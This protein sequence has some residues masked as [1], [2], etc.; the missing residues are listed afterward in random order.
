MDFNALFQFLQDLQ[1]NNHKEWMDANRKQYQT[2][3]NSFIQWLDELD[4]KLAAID[5]N[6]YPTS[7]K[8]GINRINNNL[9]FHPNKPVYKDHFAAGLDQRTK[10]GDFYI[11]IGIN[12]C[13]LAGG[14]WRPENK[15]LNSIREA[16]DYNGEELVKILNKKSFKQTF[17]GMYLDKDKLKTTPKGYSS[18]HEY[19]DLLRH[20]TFAV[21][22]PLNQKDILRDDFMDK[23][24]TVYKEMLPFRRYF[25]QAVTV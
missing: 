19:I 9:L 15:M 18:D 14:Y 22:H 17:G 21:I 5:P 16:I 3:R 2:I 11:Q 6:Y 20:R 10:Q 12:E 13:E 8:K 24:I 1:A 23:V 7:G 4:G 25:N